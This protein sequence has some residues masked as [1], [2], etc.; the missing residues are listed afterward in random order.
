MEWSLTETIAL[1]SAHCVHCRGFGMYTLIKG[2][3]RPCDCVFRAIFR[4]CYS[5]F[6]DCV[7]LEKSCGTSS[8]EWTDR[9][10]CYRKNPRRI[11]EY[12]ADF[13][14]VSRRALEPEDYQIFR[15]HYLLGADWKLCCRRLHIDPTK[16]FHHVYRIERRLGRVF[17]E[18]EPYA[19][20]PLDEYFGGS[21][22][23]DHVSIRVR[24]ILKRSHA[25][26]V[27]AAL[28]KIA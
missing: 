9:T 28:K 27:T 12:L 13:S 5:R 6:R 16:F 23:K 22:R 26:A 21:V 18:L 19:L 24:Q 10:V 2:R 17:R 1:A 14:S 8:M 7:E 11:E 20:Y 25:R 4:A 3:E 15:Y